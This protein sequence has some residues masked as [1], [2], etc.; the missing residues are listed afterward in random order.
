[1]QVDEGYSGQQSA[2]ERVAATNV[3]KFS[4]LNCERWQLQV[5]SEA[6]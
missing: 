4:K 5:T 2:M 3:N 6:D 1:M